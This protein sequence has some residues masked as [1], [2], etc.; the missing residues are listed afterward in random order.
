MTNGTGNQ[1]TGAP[2]GLAEPYGGVPA[3]TD[4]QAIPLTQCDGR[5]FSIN[6]APYIYA[7]NRSATEVGLLWTLSSGTRVQYILDAHTRQM[8]ILPGIPIAV[9]AYDMTTYTFG[10]LNAPLAAGTPFLAPA[11]YA[12]IQGAMVLLS[13]SDTP[14]SIFSDQRQ[15]PSGLS[16]LLVNTATGAV[17][18][19]TPF[20][21]SID[22]SGI[23]SLALDVRCLP[24]GT[25]TNW[26]VVIS[27]L[28]SL[29]SATATY[30]S[31]LM[32]GG[33]VVATD[34]GVGSQGY[35]LSQVMLYTITVT[36]GGGTSFLFN[37]SG[38][39]RV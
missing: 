2:F 29:L 3:L 8:V 7:D 1:N 33:D 24:G 9:Q 38:T 30:T 39:G 4:F 35:L 22:T 31:P 14:W 21:G 11:E 37:V 17:V 26:Q 12:P 13:T 36:G 28:D 34:W 18:V 32:A 19:G 16:K 23:D 10:P 25:A 20:A 15:E 27:R 6:P 5:V